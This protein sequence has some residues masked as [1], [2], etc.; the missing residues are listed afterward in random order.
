MTVLGSDNGDIRA[1][2]ITRNKQGHYVITEES[3]QQYYTMILNV[4]TQNN[5]ISTHKAKYIREK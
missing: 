1:K 4:C 3:F 2:K 5:G